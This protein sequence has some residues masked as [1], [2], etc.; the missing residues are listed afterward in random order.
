MKKGDTIRVVC[1]GEHRAEIGSI[2]KVHEVKDH[3]VIWIK[4]ESK[5]Y[6]C[7]IPIEYERVD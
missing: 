2:Q 4:T 6:H 3:G 1:E 5:E 7:L